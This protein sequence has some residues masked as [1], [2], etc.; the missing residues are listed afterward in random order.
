M[1]NHYTK[2]NSRLKYDFQRQDHVQVIKNYY[3]IKN[4]CQTLIIL[5]IRLNIGQNKNIEK[6]K[7]IID[8]AIYSLMN[9]IY[10]IAI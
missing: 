8:F 7:H 5:D 4:Y 3:Q 2:R 10:I 9:I 1:E 6:K